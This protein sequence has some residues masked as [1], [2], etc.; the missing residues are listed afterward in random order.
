MQHGRARDT[1]GTQCET[2][3]SVTGI[4]GIQGT[5][6]SPGADVEDESKRSHRGIGR[7]VGSEGA[8]G[9]EEGRDVAILRG[10]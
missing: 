5:T 1:I 2:G 7:T 4:G 10:L 8:A 6:Y 9:P 3:I